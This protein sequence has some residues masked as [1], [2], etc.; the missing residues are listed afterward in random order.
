MPHTEIELRDQN[1]TAKICLMLNILCVSF[2]G[3]FLAILA[4]FTFK[5]CTA[6]SRK[7]YWN[8]YFKS[9]RSFGRKP[10][11]HEYFRPDCTAFSVKPLIDGLIV[12]NV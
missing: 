3:S 6:K 1:F 7:T 11:T 5:T 4:Q 2:R 8:F 12:W 9:L 10:E